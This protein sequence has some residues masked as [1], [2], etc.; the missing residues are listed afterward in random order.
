MNADPGAAVPP[1][2]KEALRHE[3]VRRLVATA[4]RM[5]TPHPGGRIMWHEWGQGPPVVLLHGNFGSWLHWLRNIDS[6]A[7]RFR[8]LAADLPGLGESD[9]VPQAAPTPAEFAA[10]LIAGLRALTGETEP[11]RVVSFS[12]GAAAGGQ[13][14]HSLRDRLRKVVLIGPPGLSDIWHNP[15]D[16]LQRRHRDMTMAERRAVIRNNLLLTMIADPAAIDDLTLDLQ[17]DLADQRQ[18][19]DG[20][21]ISRSEALAQIVPDLMDR[22]TIVWGERDNY[23]APDV[24]TVAHQLRQRRPG[25]D[26]RILPGAGHWA[27]HEAAPAFNALLAGVLAE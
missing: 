14:A 21:P 4:R 22:L 12:L 17:S 26:I 1:Y 23:I 9:P 11:L 5:T 6:L 27:A 18:K 16:H 13:V 2:L 19:L 20:K 8:V 24:A 25:I 7:K 10:P 3:S 15:N